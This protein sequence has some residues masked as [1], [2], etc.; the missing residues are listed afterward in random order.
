MK[1][2]L[3]SDRFASVIGKILESASVPRFNEVQMKRLTTA[4]V[5]LF[6][7]SAC[8]GVTPTGS[9]GNGGTGSGG[10][11]PD[12]GQCTT[13]DTSKCEPPPSRCAD[14]STLIYFTD[15]QCASGKCVWKESQTTC[16]GGCI[17]NGCQFIGTAVGAP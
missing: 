10:P 8:G 13:N 4:L 11:L 12:A 17:G 6:I 14:S 7:V 15:V 3:N 2:R 5:V 1:T 9:G 16:R